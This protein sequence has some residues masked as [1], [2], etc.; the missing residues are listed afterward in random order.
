MNIKKNSTDNE[1]SVIKKH[2]TK[3]FII[4]FIL[5]IFIGLAKRVVPAVKTLRCNFH[6]LHTDIFRKIMIQI[7]PNLFRCF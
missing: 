5:G 2:S 4:A 1:I 6:F 3:S 7:F